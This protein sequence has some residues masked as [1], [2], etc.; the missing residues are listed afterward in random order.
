MTG[1]LLKTQAVR[2]SHET[3][4]LYGSLSRKPSDRREATLVGSSHLPKVEGWV[5]GS[6]MQEELFCDALTMAIWQRPQGKAQHV[7]NGRPLFKCCNAALSFGLSS[8][9]AG[10]KSPTT[11]LFVLDI[12]MLC[13]NTFALY[14][15]I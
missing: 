14:L 3:L 15:T 9:R 11:A 7:G 2:S 4:S 12:G 6:R 13:L 10:F 1:W 8:L 5:M